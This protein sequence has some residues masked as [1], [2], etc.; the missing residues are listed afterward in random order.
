[1]RL[2]VSVDVIDGESLRILAAGA[3]PAVVVQDLVADAV[4][5]AAVSA[6]FSL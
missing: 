1:V 2:T 6:A 4:M 3:G 5:L